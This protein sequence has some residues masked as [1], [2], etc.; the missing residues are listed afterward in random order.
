MK[1]KIMSLKILVITIMMLM[2]SSVFG[3]AVGVIRVNRERESNREVVS[4]TDNNIETKEIRVAIYTDEIENEEFY[5]PYGRTRYFMWALSDY[6]WKVGKT[7]YRF[8]ATL[9]PTKSLLRGDLTTNK[10]D[11]LL[12]PPDTADEN[13]F[14]TGFSRLPRNIIR[15]RNIANFIKDGG[16]YFGTCGGALI[17][18]GMENKPKTFLEKM[19]KNSCLGISGVNVQF[20][21]GI[22]ILCQMAGFGPET[23]GTIAYLLYSGWN[24]TN[25][26][27]NYH[28]GACL[29]VPVSQDNPIFDDY[30][31]VTRKIRWI[32]SPAFVIPEHPDR[33]ITVLAR[34][35]AEEASDNESIRI[36]YWKYTGGIRGLIS[37]F[38]RGNGEI[39]WFEN[40]GILMKA[41]CFASDWE[42][43]KLAKTNFSN[44]PFMTAEIY[45]N[46]NKARVVRCSGHPEHN[47]WWGGC[48]KEAEDT[49]KNNM[50]E[51]FYR[52]KDVIPEEETIEDEFSYNYW[53]NRRSVAWVSKKVPDNDLPPI[54]GP[55]QVSDIYPYNQPSNFTIIGNAETSDGIISLDLYY[56]YSNDNSS[57][58]DWIYYGTDTNES[59][60]W[61]W[62]F[63]ASTVNGSGYYQFYS[64]RRVQ[65]EHEW[66]NET[67]PPGP[68]AIVKIN[69]PN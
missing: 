57:W 2:V 12:Y 54:Y 8:V 13:L 21:A 22:P 59:D 19:F 65:Y 5:G 30:L 45:P 9:L 25:Y 29:D 60:G 18:G 40:F 14:I 11:V 55:S 53:I 28:T 48:I 49:D 67:A 17:A 4:A 7:S 51:A 39:H 50:Y 68:D 63:N 10:Y 61:S 36:H 15:E 38:I 69:W 33:E 41:F 26:S 42:R 56:Q 20:K 37:A 27:I 23:V 6:S 46:E 3:S 58:S 62:E 34:F 32:G 31:E 47:V 43:D 64:I 24:Q 52:W 1:G 16:G 35:P 44:K 66:L